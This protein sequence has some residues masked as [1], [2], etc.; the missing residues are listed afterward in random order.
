VGRRGH[1]DDGFAGTAEYLISRKNAGK[2]RIGDTLSAAAFCTKI[3]CLGKAAS[4]STEP[5][6]PNGLTD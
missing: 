5:Q 4:T 2:C 3:V 1:V 6:K